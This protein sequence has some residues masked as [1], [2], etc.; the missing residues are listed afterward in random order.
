MNKILF[1]TT[2]ANFAQ[3]VRYQSTSTKTYIGSSILLQSRQSQ[4][5]CLFSKFHQFFR[6]W[7]NGHSKFPFYVIFAERYD[8]VTISSRNLI[9]CLT[10]IFR[11]QF[12]FL[13]QLNSFF[14]GAYKLLCLFNHS[15]LNFVQVQTS[16]HEVSGRKFS[17]PKIWEDHLKRMS[18]CSM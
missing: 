13:S 16:L 6:I 14:I 10:K 18:K 11:L 1:L 12:G 3:S 9:I 8:T 4:L 7:K 17:L 15:L 2:N 5:Y